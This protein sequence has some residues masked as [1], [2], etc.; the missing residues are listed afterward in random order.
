MFLSVYVRVSVSSVSLS[1]C[2]CLCLSLSLHLSLSLSLSLYVCVC[3]VC[4]SVSLSVCLCLCLSVS[5][6]LSVVSLTHTHPKRERERER[7]MREREMRERNEIYRDRAQPHVT[8]NPLSLLFP[9]P[10]RAGG[11]AELD[12]HSRGHTGLARTAA[13]RALATATS[14]IITSL[15]TSS[16]T[17]ATTTTTTAEF[18]PRG[19]NAFGPRGAAEAE[20][21]RS[22]CRVCQASKTGLGACVCVMCFPCVSHIIMAFTLFCNFFSTQCSSTNNSPDSKR[23]FKTSSQTHSLFATNRS[24]CKSTPFVTDSTLYTRAR[25]LWSRLACF[26]FFFFSQKI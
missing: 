1:L 4:Q 7:E 15:P 5:L 9:K 13:Q 18:R 24:R 25:C 20:A 16:T 26:S 2:L 10:A 19:A 12:A 11:H 8:F 21:E 17:T 3:S 6:S 22:G 23:Q 14:G